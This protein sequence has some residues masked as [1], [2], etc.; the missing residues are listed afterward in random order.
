MKYAV[1]LA[2]YVNNTNDL[3]FFLGI[4]VR[5]QTMTYRSKWNTPKH[6]IPIFFTMSS[7]S[8]GFSSSSK[9]FSHVLGRLL[10]FELCNYLQSALPNP[11]ELHSKLYRRLF[12]QICSFRPYFG[13]K[14]EHT[15]KRDWLIQNT[16]WWLNKKC[17]VSTVSTV[18]DGKHNV[19]K[20]L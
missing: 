12:L 3:K 19:F 6:P 13:S 9:M 4:Y 15:N 2:K 10:F 20:L 7:S 1:S 17:L 16:K 8:S 11:P 5:N 14:Q 18:S